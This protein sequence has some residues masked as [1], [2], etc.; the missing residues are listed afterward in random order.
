MALFRSLGDTTRL[1]I[2]QRLTCGEARVTDLVATLGLA[3]STIS[4]HLSCL[5]GCG[6]VDSRAA[7]RASF[8]HLARPELI[9]LLNS[10][11]QLLATTGEVTALSPN[12]GI[13]A[14]PGEDTPW[15]ARRDAG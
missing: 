3:Q 6:L 4:A 8:Y 14:S 2:L 5:R 7:G 12:Y 10:A 13:S 15:A 11:E 1:A 9:D